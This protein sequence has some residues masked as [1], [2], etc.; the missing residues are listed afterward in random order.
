M[1]FIPLAESTGFI[2]EISR[3]MFPKLLADLLIINDINDELTISFNLSAQ[4]FNSPEMLNLIRSAIIS[5][6]IKPERLQVELTE[7]SIINSNDAAV[8]EN[9]QELAKLGVTLAMDDYGTGYSSIESL[10]KWPFSILKIDQGLIQRMSGSKKCTTIVQAS[11]RMAHQLGI[12]TVAE[13]I[14]TASIYDFLLHAGCTEAQGFW[15]AK[16]MTLE[17]LVLFIKKDQ[18]WSGVP[19]GLIHMA[20][21]DHIHWRKT[22]IE[23]ITSTSFG[24]RRHPEFCDTNIEMEHHGCRLGLWYYGAGQEFKGRRS[25]DKLEEPHRILH[26]IGKELLSSAKDGASR[27]NVTAVLRK[28]TK[29][30]SIVL[31]LLQ[32]LENEALMEPGAIIPDDFLKL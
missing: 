27:E 16:P 19:I 10:S 21:L 1:D 9:L 29:Q 22:L 14:E 30:S 23:Q 31:E 17:D 24:G 8:R 26:D 6:Q 20:Q 15:L 18:R 11:I 4:D 25:F 32:E 12:G 5:R 7:A 28:L 2:S 13:G 3:V